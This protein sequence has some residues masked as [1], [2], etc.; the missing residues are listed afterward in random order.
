M[1]TDF[2]PVLNALAHLALALED[3]VTVLVNHTGETPDLLVSE[4]QIRE[5][6]LRQQTQTTTTNPSKPPLPVKTE[7][8]ITI[9]KVRKILA[10]K[11]QAGKQPE[12]KA[13]INCYGVNRLTE[14]DPAKY[15]EL[16]KKAEEL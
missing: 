9:E 13:L 1:N 16:I 3:F 14:I 12:V 7:A 2:K 10:E 6:L 4:P 8:S 5:L 15:S 11:S